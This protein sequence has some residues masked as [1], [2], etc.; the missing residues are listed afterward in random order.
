MAKPRTNYILDW[1]AYGLFSLLAGTGVLL[2]FRLP[3][4]SGAATLLGLDR[5][6]WGDLHFWIAAAFLA[7]VAA[8]LLLHAKWIAAL[9]TAKAQGPRRKARTAGAIAGGALGVAAILAPLLLATPAPQ[10]EG[11]NHGHENAASSPAESAQDR[12]AHGEGRG[13]GGGQ[14]RGDGQGRGRTAEGGGNP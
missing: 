13:A 10:R 12:S 8:H 11:R 4:G 9:T 14:G 2:H 7:V 6:Q 3:H 5:H 1:T